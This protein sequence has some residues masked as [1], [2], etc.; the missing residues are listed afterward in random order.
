MDARAQC[1]HIHHSKKVTAMPRFTASGL[2]KK[3][4]YSCLYSRPNKSGYIS[5]QFMLL[6]IVIFRV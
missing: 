4:Q 5:I 2:D 6:A 3:E 1:T